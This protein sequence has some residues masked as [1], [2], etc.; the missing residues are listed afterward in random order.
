MHHSRIDANVSVRLGHG[1]RDVFEI[2]RLRCEPV[3]GRLSSNVDNF[4]PPFS[5]LRYDFLRVADSIMTVCPIKLDSHEF[6]WQLQIEIDAQSNEV[7]VV[8]KRVI[9]I[10]I[11]EMKFLMV[12]RL[13]VV[14]DAVQIEQVYEFV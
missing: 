8:V 14:V 10:R 13:P 3:I 9:A 6:L 5:P 7:A 2:T 11:M 12:H 1:I 4:I